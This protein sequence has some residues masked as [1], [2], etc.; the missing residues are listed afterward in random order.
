MPKLDLTSI[1][2]GLVGSASL[3][4][5]P[6]HTAPRIGSGR[7]P[8]LATPVMIVCSRPPRWRQQSLF[9]PPGIKAWGSVSTCAIS[10]RHQW[11][12]QLL[13]PRRL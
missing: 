3:V 11:G 9:C 2:S 13:R 12:S 8:V 4:V 5:G 7:I 10:R 6:E 1:H